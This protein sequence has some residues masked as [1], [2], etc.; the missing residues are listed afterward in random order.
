MM[1]RTISFGM[2]GSPDRSKYGNKKTVRHGMEFDSKKEADRYDVL[3]LLQR[4]GDVRNI[5]HHVRY[6]FRVNGILIAWYEAD[7]VYEERA[8]FPMNGGAA[9]TVD[10]VWCEI[11]EDVKGFPAKTWPMKK[12]LLKA[13][14]GIDVRVT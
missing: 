6:D 14:H 9:A 13:I 2:R 8:R 3:L 7:F 5:R 4:A 10:G 12:K 1:S 11:V